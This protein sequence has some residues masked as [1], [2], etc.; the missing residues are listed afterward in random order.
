MKTNK[1]KQ[2]SLSLLVAA[3]LAGGAV[4]QSAGDPLLAPFNTAF[5]DLSLPAAGLPAQKADLFPLAAV[6][7][8]DSPFKEA[9]QTD[10][11]YLLRLDPDRLLAFDRVNAGLAPKAAHYGGWDNSG[12]STIGHYLSACSQMAQATGDP[13]LR[14]RVDYVVSELAACQ[15]ANGD[16]GI[17]GYAWDKKTY[18]PALR[19][20]KVIVTNTSPWYL[21]HKTFAGLRDAAVL[22]GSTEARDVLIKE[23]DWAID[24]TSHLTDTQWQEMLGPPDKM[25]EFGGPHEIFADV[26]GMTGDRKYLTLAEHFKHD[27]IFDPLE[28]NDVS[29]LNGKHANTEIPK[30]VGYERIYE[31]TGDPSYH[32]AAQNFWNNVTSE[33][34]WANGGNS[35]WEHFFAPDDYGKE[36]EAVSGP[37]T[38][39]TYNMLKLTAALYTRDP[40]ASYLDYY[41]NALYNHILPSEA[42]GGGFVYYTPMRPGHYRVFSRDYDAFWCCVGTGMENHGKY[43]EMIY[44]HT[45][46]DRLFVNLF[47]P[48]TLTWPGTGT[49]VSQQTTFPEKPSTH[50]ALT[51]KAPQQ[52]TLSVRYPQWIAPGAM[53]IKVNGKAVPV[54]ATPGTYADITRV[55]KQGDVVDV[56]L[57]MR[58]RT[59]ALP[60]DPSY[61]AFFYGPVLLAGKM[62]TAGLTP[63][64]FHGGGNNT[65]IGNQLASKKEP[66]SLTPALLTTPANALS[67]LQP[68]KGKP[69]TFQIAGSVAKPD[70]VT[71]VPFYQVFFER[72]ALYWPLMDSATYQANLGKAEAEEKAARNAE[73][74]AI[75]RVHVGESDSEAAH[76]L[77]SDHSAIGGAAAPLTHW[78]D[79]SGYFSYTVKVLPDAPVA[80]RT[81]Y[82]GSDGGRTFDISVD[83]TTIA[84]QTLSGAK[85]N[86]YLYVTY[87]IPPALTKGK[88]SV[89]VRFTPKVGNAGGLFDLRV[90]KE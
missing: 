24:V 11:A 73:A 51:L 44:A 23:A 7:L 21:I 46:K 12:A 22:C 78:R 15:K 77:Q 66:A 9:Q 67:V 34:T 50:L 55:W 1:T 68:V 38:C 86:E 20:G 58:L 57:P 18:F 49:T 3:M 33:R 61:Q 39:N 42:P 25:G 32:A 5:S 70:A 17:Y 13:V 87:P 43:G 16:G 36:V 83:G 2:I 71:L 47:I 89:T 29:V 72:Y 10:R 6:R 35:Q 27:I 85:P 81:A 75:D 53:T 19:T 63:A 28:K 65:N 52:M 56:A 48:S 76:N 40:K 31:L 82:W 64:D 14:K 30:F 45:G 88:N 69:L 4:K 60:G 59:E 8:D 41:E 80:L 54:T 74:A 37:E 90:L 62:G 26:Y 84:T 79:A